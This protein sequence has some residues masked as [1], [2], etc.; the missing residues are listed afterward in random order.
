MGRMTLPTS[1]AVWD[2][3]EHMAAESPISPTSDLS[4]S[5]MTIFDRTARI[6]LELDPGTGL[7]VALLNRSGE[8]ARRLPVAMS[9]QLDTE[10]TEVDRQPF[11]LDY[12]DVTVLQEVR[13]RAEGVT[14]DFLGQDEVFTVATDVGAWRLDIE[15]RFRVASPRLEIHLIVAPPEDGP[16]GTLRNLHLRFRIEPG[17]LSGWRL[18]APTSDLRSGVPLARV[19][20]ETRTGDAE[21]GGSGLVVIDDPAARSALLIWPLSRTEQAN[22]SIQAHGSDVTFTV[23]TRMAG[24][25][26]TGQRLR[27]GGVELDFLDQ[28]W[29]E[30]LPGIQS[31]YGP[32]GIAAPNDTASW[33]PGASLY[34][35]QIGTS[36]F[37]GGWEYSPYPT[38]RDLH[39]DV[40]RI[41]GLGFD[42]IQIMPHQPFPSYNVYDYHDVTL[43][44]G[45]ED[46]LRRVVEAAHA[47]GMRVIL[48]ILMHGVIDEKMITATADRVRNGPYFDRLDDGTGIQ[49]NEDFTAYKGYDYLV[50]WARHILDFEPHWAGGSPGDHP[51]A[52]EHPEW[53]VRKSSGEIIGVYTKAFD[54]NNV[55]WQEY[56][57][58]VCLMLVQRLGVD[59]FRFDAPTYND[60]PNWSPATEHRASASQLGAVDHFARLRSEIKSRY[61]D[62][63]L[64]T[65]PSG[66][67]F[68]QTMDI[69]YNY[70]E[71][72]LIPAVIRPEITG[73]P[74]RIGMRSSRDPGDLGIRTAR[75]LAGWFRNKIATLPKGS[76]TARHIDSHDSFWWPLPGFKWRRE[77]YGIPATRALVATWSLSGG[78]YMMFV[79]GEVGIEEDIRRANRLKRTIPEIRLGAADYDGVSVADDRIYAVA[80]V[81][82]GRRSLVL[83]NLSGETVATSCALADLDGLN[84]PTGYIVHD[85]WQDESLPSADGYSWDATRLGAIYQTLSRIR[86]AS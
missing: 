33:I 8:A 82:D 40:G 38:A 2:M 41:A 9:L 15:Y 12:V 47:H 59:G 70:D 36:V 57:T 81:L 58:S 46:D 27:W 32:L 14:H 30:L 31:W 22:G 25:I 55:A 16:P 61:P 53:F 60:V 67:L 64:Y 48:D 79:G 39:D 75:D 84:S 11:G 23:E 51:L 74:T 63:L 21:F 24:R 78:V 18:F 35:V 10:G 19:T 50:S 56:F 3:E 76:I 5:T 1:D 4:A 43:S 62:A 68:R 29:E 28:P 54:T 83:V 26:G 6:G 52:A 44:Y 65:E 85:V 80:R 71:H 66:V 34:E 72:P 77:Q 45:D 17:D 20:E 86:S 49:P 42:C 73:D 7:P 37:W 13:L 69:V